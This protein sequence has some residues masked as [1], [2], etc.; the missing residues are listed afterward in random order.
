MR[1]PTD[2]NAP[3]PRYWKITTGIAG[4]I[5]LVTGLFVKSWLSGIL[6]LALV[7]VTGF[8]I[9]R[10]LLLLSQDVPVIETAQDHALRWGAGTAV[11]LIALICFVVAS[12]PSRPPP[13]V[14]QVQPASNAGVINCMRVHGMKKAY[15]ESPSKELTRVEDLSDQVPAEELYETV[16]RS[17]NNPPLPG[18]QVAGRQA[19]GYAEIV[20]TRMEGPDP[21]SRNFGSAYRVKAPECKRLNAKF[22][23]SLSG[24]DV[25]RWETLIPIERT[26]YYNGKPWPSASDYGKYAR[27]EDQFE[28][29]RDETVI[30]S[31]LNANLDHIKCVG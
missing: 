29:H 19:D 9:Y 7:F 16:F 25:R 11:V 1:E 2:H 8:V 3:T 10:V 26:V 4:V 12:G 31:H 30:I 14:T 27:V 22:T 18:E 20:A 17:C 21:L 23:L 28:A 24:M 13:T 5:S 6:V 15:E